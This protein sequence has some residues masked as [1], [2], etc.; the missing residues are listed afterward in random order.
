MQMAQRN[1]NIQPT[2]EIRPGY[3]F[4]VMVTKDITLPAWEGDTGLQHR[5]LTASGADFPVIP[6]QPNSDKP[7]SRPGSVRTASV[8]PGSKPLPLTE[9]DRPAR[10]SVK[11]PPLPLPVWRAE[12]GSTLK[13][14][15]F[16]WSAAQTCPEGG[17][18]R[19]IWETAVNYPIDA[20]LR[21]EGDFNAALNGLF[22][23]YQ[24]AQKPLYAV[25]NRT[26]C[27]IKVTDKG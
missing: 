17:S 20:P 16:R 2:L 15:L 12:A 10:M 1:M 18:W 25:T 27:L 23:L 22:G 6:S 7:Q 21:F 26:Q 24:Q 5:Q 19:V 8:V 3:E 4:N 9:H 11:K 13:A 14:T